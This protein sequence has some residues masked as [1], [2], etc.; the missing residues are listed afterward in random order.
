[1]KK[2][3][4]VTDKGDWFMYDAG[5]AMEHL[6]LTAWSIGLGT[7]HVGAFDA[8]KAEATLAIPEGFS[9]VAMTPLGYF[10]EQPD[11]RPRKGLDEILYL[12]QFGK[13]LQ[14]MNIP[15]MDLKT[16]YRKV[17]RKLL[18]KLR[19]ILSEQRLTTGRYCAELEEGIAAFPGCPTPFPARA[20]RMPSFSRSW[21]SG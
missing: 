4:A 14:Q 7:V 19:E 3:E 8:K 10:E 21:R 6:V 13:V 15:L 18:P 16:P 11:P 5:I 20:A 9:V 1:M 2:G 12:D 17:E